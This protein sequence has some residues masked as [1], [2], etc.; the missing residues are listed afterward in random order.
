MCASNGV[1]VNVIPDIGY[2]HSSAIR[3]ELL[4][5]KSQPIPVVSRIYNA[6]NTSALAQPVA[7]FSSTVR[8]AGNGLALRILLGQVLIY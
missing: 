8:I 1:K 2:L 7:V 6:A 4:Y 3:V 5:Q